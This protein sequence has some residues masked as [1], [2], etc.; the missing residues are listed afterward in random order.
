MIGASLFLIAQIYHIN[1]NS[2][3][4]IL[5]WIM[6][7]LPLVYAFHSMDIAVPDFRAG[8][9]F[10]LAALV[11]E[12]ASTLS[13]IEH[14]DRGYESLEEKLKGVGVHIERLST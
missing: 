2:H 4:L 9:A 5:I 14:L 3:V 13:G 7:N 8:L 6:A 10:V 11:A 1:A 12:G